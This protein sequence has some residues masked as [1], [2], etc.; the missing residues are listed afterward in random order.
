LIAAAGRVLATA[1]NGGDLSLR[2]VAR[3]AG[4]A[5]PSVYLQFS[6]KNELISAVVSQFFEQLRDAVLAAIATAADPVARLRAGCLAYCRFGLERP[7]AYHIL[8]QAGPP[9]G[10]VI[11]AFGDLNDAGTRAFATLVDAVR[12][13]MAAGIVRPGDPFR[14]A[15]LLWAAMHGYVTL[16]QTRRGF[17]WQPVDAFV[18]DLI[19]AITVTGEDP[20]SAT[21]SE[22]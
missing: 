18:D 2:A 14:Q 22:R 15:S 17:P 19:A 11:G 5:A 13:C 21:V 12:D 8:F 1:P 20:V 6:D 4:V 7:G 10:H 9:A 3:E 16:V